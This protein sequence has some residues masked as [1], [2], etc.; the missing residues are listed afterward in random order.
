[1]EELC[2]WMEILQDNRQAGNQNVS[3]KKAFQHWHGTCRV[4]RENAKDSEIRCPHRAV[5]WMFM[6][7]S[8]CLSNNN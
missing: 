7:L 1:M 4:S 3:A 8:C 6:R 5:G 2:E